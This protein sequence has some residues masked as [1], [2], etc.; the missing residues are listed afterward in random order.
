MFC[1]RPAYHGLP[2]GVY[3]MVFTA[4]TGLQVACDALVMPEPSPAADLALAAVLRRLRTESG[5]SQESVAYRAG[6]T[7]GSL[8]RIELGQAS[9]EWATVRRIA[10]ALGV[11][12]RDL[13]AAVEEEEH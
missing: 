5:V 10:R 12:L 1:L 8:T 4:W 9:P 13:A 11:S 7:A 6:L 2:P 3:Y